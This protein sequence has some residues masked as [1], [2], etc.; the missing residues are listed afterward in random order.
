MDTSHPASADES[1][2]DR[3]PAAPPSADASHAA[4]STPVDADEAEQAATD[5]DADEPEPAGWGV[6]LDLAVL[7]SIRERSTIEEAWLEE[8]TRAALGL[9]GCERGELSVVI[10]DDE[11][12]RTAHNE[13][14]G[15]DSTT[16]VLTFNLGEGETPTDTI[17]AEIY[18]CVDE[19]ARQVRQ[20]RHSLP[21][22]LLLYIIHGALHCLGYDDTEAEQYERMHRREDEILSELGVG[23]TFET[24]RNVARRDDRHRPRARA[25]NTEDSTT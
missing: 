5:A 6:R 1:E 7:D 21:R 22:E 17:D 24:D 10:V 2:A 4:R 15:I 19:A 25:D 3:E 9:L 20:R 8:K 18:I 14:L 11:T 16:D 12:M 13:H 23:A